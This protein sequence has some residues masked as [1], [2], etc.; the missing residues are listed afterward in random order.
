[1]GGAAVVAAVAA[2]AA[3]AVATVSLLAGAPVAAQTLF[4]LDSAE[5]AVRRTHPQARRP[6]AVPTSDIT[7][8]EGLVYARPDGAGPGLALDIV[9]PAEATPRPRPAVLLVHGGGWDGGSRQMEHTLADHLAARGWVVVP[10]SYRLGAPG[11]YPAAL[12]DLQ[13]ALR[14]LQQHAAERQIDPRRL[15]VIGASSGGQLAALLGARNDAGVPLRAVVDIDGLADF[16]DPAFVAQQ[17]RSPS[18][19]TRFLG[20]PQAERAAV[21]HDASAL[22]HAG[23]HSA[24][25]LFINSTAASPPLPGRPALRARLRAAGVVAESVTLDD[26]PHPFWLFEPWFSPVLALCDD[27]LRRQLGAP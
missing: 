12:H 5:A 11:R 7:R 22:S 8:T 19:P 13:A 2:A 25:T 23:A 17:A 16:T 18:A 24:A 10:V 27:F 1:M 26:S 6:A 14:W 9:R 4:T 15:A 21:W 3:A 20:G